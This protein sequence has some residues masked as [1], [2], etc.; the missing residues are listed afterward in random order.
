LRAIPLHLLHAI[1]TELRTIKFTCAQGLAIAR[2]QN[3]LALET[4]DGGKEF[5]YE[6]LKTFK[7]TPSPPI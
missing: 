4:L 5:W 2:K 1:I 6:L 7:I 3:P